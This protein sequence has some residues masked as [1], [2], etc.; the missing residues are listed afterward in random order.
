MTSNKLEPETIYI[1]EQTLLIVSGMGAERAK[2]ATEKLIASGVDVLVSMGTA[3]AT[4]ADVQTGDLV[5]PETV[6]T[7]DGRVYETAKYWRLAILNKLIDCPNNIFLGQLADAMHV[8]T[9]VQDKTSIEKHNA[10][11]A[12]DMESASITEIAAKN[13][14]PCVVIRAVSDSSDMIIPEAVMKVTDPYGKVKVINLLAL[15]LKNPDQILHLIKLARGFWD[16]CSSLKWIGQRLDTILN[17]SKS[18]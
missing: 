10:T 1:S 14:I 5:V 4:Q 13:K 7:L 2:R 15:L 6:V 8:L 3:G 12:V 17:N 18:T 16:A 11:I 9:T